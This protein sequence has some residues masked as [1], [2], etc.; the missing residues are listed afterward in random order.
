MIRTGRQLKFHSLTKRQTARHFGGIL[1][2]G[3][4]KEKRPLSNKDAIHLVLKSQLAVGGRSFLQKKNSV[5]IESIIR[6][7]AADNGLKIYHFVNVGNHLHLVV[8][9]QQS[10]LAAGR[11][12]FHSFIRAVTGLIA[13]HVLGAER[14]NRKGIK[15][16]QARPFTRILSW[17]RDYNFICR[18]MAKNAATAKARRAMI[19]W[20]F[21]PTDPEKILRLE[22]G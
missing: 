5:R 20:G 9:L 6:K 12:A 10:N 11:A 21:T 3:N 16:W 4:A 19:A 8:K 15:F 14:N 13:R 18:Y 22:T 17:G 7:A 1:L 2:R